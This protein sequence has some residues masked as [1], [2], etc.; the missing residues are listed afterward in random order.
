MKTKTT[1]LF[2]HSTTPMD[3]DD[4]IQ[5]YIDSLAQVDNLAKRKRDDEGGEGG[6]NGSSSSSSSDSDSDRSSK[7]RR[8]KKETAE[9]LEYKRRKESP[10]GIS[11]IAPPA[12]IDSL[13]KLLHLCKNY[14]GTQVDWKVLWKLVEPLS[15][16]NSLI[17]MRKVKQQVV[18]TILYFVGGFHD[19][20]SAT[21]MRHT[22]LQSSPGM[23]KS[24]LAP[25]LARIYCAMGFLKT[26]N[27]ITVRREQLIGK[28]IGHSEDNARRIFNSA[29]DGVLLLDEAYSLGSGDRVDSFSKAVIDMLNQ[30]LSEHAHHFI[31]IIAGYEKE[32][33]DSLF[34]VN[35]GLKRRFPIKFEIEKYSPF[36]LYQIFI[37]KATKEGWSCKEDFCSLFTDNKDYFGDAGG[38]VDNLY[39]YCKVSHSERVFGTILEKKVLTRCDIM[40]GLDMLRERK[41]GNIEHASYLSMYL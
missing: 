40:K 14:Y 3:S 7:R 24:L 27:V 4:D 30:F 20:S 36:E 33:N 13:D 29:I 2:I 5:A 35:P 23:G 26:S 34:S 32:L 12:N 9:E 11:E 21:Q 6:D 39:G 22:I 8:R 31:C 25:I 38:D 1:I 18:S 15:D 16:L 19:S 10:D 37:Q 17:G 28:Y 41:G